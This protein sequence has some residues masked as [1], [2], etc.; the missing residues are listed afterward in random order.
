MRSMREFI[1][2]KGFLVL[3]QYSIMLTCNASERKSKNEKSNLR[4]YSQR[5]T[6]SSLMNRQ[7]QKNS[8]LISFMYVLVGIV[9]CQ[10]LFFFFCAS[11]FW[12][13]NAPLINTFYISVILLAKPFRTQRDYAITSQDLP[14]QFCVDCEDQLSSLLP[15]TSGQSLWSRPLLV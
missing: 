7:P 15:S 11:S 9:K 1:A 6:V 10:T 2:K 14:R 12:P 8:K 4:V 13:C 3:D 5:K